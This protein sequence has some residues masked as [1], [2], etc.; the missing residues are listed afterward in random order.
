MDATEFNNYNK[1]PLYPDGTQLPKIISLTSEWVKFEPPKFKHLKSHLEKYKE[2]LLI[3]IITEG[4]IPAR[5]LTPVLFIGTFKAG[6]YI[7]GKKE[8]EYLFYL[9]DLKGLTGKMPVR[10]GWNNDNAELLEDTG[11]Y[12]EESVRKK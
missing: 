2:A 6:Y 12:I 7:R 11:F 3:T 8:N 5:A 4:P 9:F 1:R 10:W